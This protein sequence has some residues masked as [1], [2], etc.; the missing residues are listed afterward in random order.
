MA[1]IILRVLP[2]CCQDR[3]MLT[4][5][6]KEQKIHLQI[7]QVRH[8]ATNLLKALQQETDATFVV[9]MDELNA[10]FVVEQAV[11]WNM[12]LQRPILAAEPIKRILHQ[13]RFGKAV[14]ISV[15][16]TVM[17]IVPRVEARDITNINTN[18]FLF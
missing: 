8:Q 3:I 9:E 12:I 10:L 5:E 11:V 18:N 1:T 16:L 14:L 7:I 2:I 17:S 15:A 13:D 4:E 6:K